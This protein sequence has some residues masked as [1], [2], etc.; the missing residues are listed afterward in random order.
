MNRRTFL[1]AVFAAAV[2]PAS[3]VKGLYG[4]KAQIFFKGVPLV[5]EPDFTYMM[6]VNFT[7]KRRAGFIIFNHP[8]GEINVPRKQLQNNLQTSLA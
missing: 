8:K 4:P 3:V 1:K 2:A 7:C 6:P 5:Y